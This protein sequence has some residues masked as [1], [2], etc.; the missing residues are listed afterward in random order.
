[1]S[2]PP[3]TGRPTLDA[4]AARAGVSRSAASRAV[5]GAAGVSG[6]VMAKVTAAVQELGYVPN[7]AARTLVTRRTGNIAV[8][9]AEPEGR[10]FSDPYFGLQIRGISKELVAH[11][12]QLVLLLA[13][14]AGDHG[15]IDRYLAGG[16]V[17]GALAFSVHRDDPLPAIVRR[18][19]L[20]TVYGGRP[21]WTPIP[22][23]SALAYV[24]A[25]NRGGAREAVRHLVA[26]GRRRIGHIAGPQALAAGMDR[27]DGYRDVLFDG[28]PSLV[29]QGDFTDEGGERA[30]AGLLDRHPDLDALFVASDLMAR[31][32]LRALRKRGRAVPQDVAVVGFD[33]LAPV[34]TT[35]DPPLTTVRQDIEGMGR[36]MARLLIR[37]LD[38]RGSAAPAQATVITATSLVLRGSA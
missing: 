12:L 14:E 27:L 30:T 9:I 19:A 21:H 3:S 8:I 5:N 38:G 1:M 15:R 17:D 32:A 7:R 6:R 36:T 23:E 29:V 4:V 20:P 28:D 22:G 24:D 31:G 25:D 18:L 2:A 10:I 11:D 37:K 35:T 33:D 13:D 34:A 26:R 16:H